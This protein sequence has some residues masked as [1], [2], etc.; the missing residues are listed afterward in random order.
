MLRE[1]AEFPTTNIP[2]IALSYC[3]G[4]KDPAKTLRSNYQDRVRGISVAAL[5]RTYRQ[6]IHLA[7]QLGVNHLWIDALCILQDDEGDWQRESS[8][9][10]KIYSGA[11]IV[12][13]A[14]AAADVEG[15]L[16]P[17][18]D[19]S[20]WLYLNKGQVKAGPIWVR[21]KDHDFDA[22]A[23]LPISSRAWTYQE[24]LLAR[25]CLIFGE[26][27]V[28]KPQLLPSVLPSGTTGKR[29]ASS[30]D[31]HEFWSYAVQTFSEMQLTRPTDRL[32][33]ISAIASVIQA[34]T[35]DQYLAGLWRRGLLKQLAWRYHNSGTLDPPYDVY[36]APSWSWASFPSDVKI[37]AAGEPEAVCAEDAEILHVHCEPVNLCSPLGAVHHGTLALRGL[38]M[39]A[40]V[41][42]AHKYAEVQIDKISIIGTKLEFP[43]RLQLDYR[44]K[45][46]DPIGNLLRR[47]DK[48]HA[49]SSAAAGKR[50]APQ[51][52]VQLLYLTSNIFLVLSKSR[53]KHGARIRVGTLSL[54]SD[55]V[56]YDKNYVQVVHLD[57]DHVRK[58][59]LSA[60][61]REEV[62][63]I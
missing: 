32:P 20:N 28:S 1:T 36:V 43:V 60:A 22:C 7:R 42:L 16:N 17:P 27:E 15:G 14:A 4:G 11:Y 45:T 18:T 23:L 9:M 41:Q 31:A 29:F 26:G 35:G 59:L 53:R 34:E 50:E 58:D 63:I 3:W 13:V 33:A 30:Q 57:R 24:R 10:A 46:G 54:D 52:P 44:R 21:V 47:H 19:F 8:R 6:A 40:N 61:S 56:D 5:P 2:Y 37:P 25:R 38:C 51:T 12:F 62:I 55:L 39:W 48:A 49:L